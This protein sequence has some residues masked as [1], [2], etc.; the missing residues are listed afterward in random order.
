MYHRRLPVFANDCINV[1]VC[2][3]ESDGLL[4]RLFHTLLHSRKLRLCVLFG[5]MQSYLVGMFRSQ[6]AACIQLLCVGRA[7]MPG[8]LQLRLLQHSLLSV[9]IQSV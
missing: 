5:I 8:K 2:C 3:K 9:P 6:G 1:A 7:D 4:S